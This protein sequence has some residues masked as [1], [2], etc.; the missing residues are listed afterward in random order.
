[1][2]SSSK[3]Y[4]FVIPF[5]SLVLACGKKEQQAPTAPPVIPVTVMEVS[6]GEASYFDEYPGTVVSLNE[7]EL[8]PQVSGFITGVH[9]KDGDFVKKGQLLYSIDAQLYNANYDQSVAALKVQ[10]ANLVK[11]EKDAN[12]YREL[13][14]N[15][16]VATQLLDNAEASLEVARKQA[17]A[18]KAN[19]KSVQ[20]NVR[21]TK[22]H[23]PFNG[24]IGI[25]QAKPGS[26]VS[27][28]QTLLNTVSTDNQL[29]VD[30]NL[31]QNEIFRFSKMTKGKIADSTFS[32]VFGK[33]VYG[34]TGKL[35]L[36][37]RA[38]DTQTGT[39][40]VRLTFPN[41]EKMLRAGMSTTVRVLSNAAEPSIVI[42]YK[43]VT[44]QLGEYFVFVVGDSSKVHQQK[45]VSGRT[46]G[47]NIIVKEGL[48]SGDK[49]VVQ[50]VQ[51]LRE[52]TTISIGEADNSKPQATK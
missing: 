15:D 9:F 43:A 11:A 7:I 17:D 1:M 18:A 16:A 26:P 32:L 50:G 33:D 40:K 8:R 31:V 27:A 28:G 45:I 13:A 6:S 4:L 47:A 24:V 20:T 19:I 39:V 10:E 48:N 2:L 5:I 52:G 35:T 34:H 30:F 46:I 37:D 38:V 21:Y 44:E 3:K 29:A 51:N 22:I 36:I 49:I 41:P 12:R 14:K 42:P 23:S 25:S